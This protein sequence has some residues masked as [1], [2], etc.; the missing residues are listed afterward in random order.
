MKNLIILGGDHREICCNTSHVLILIGLGFAFKENSKTNIHTFSYIHTNFSI[1]IQRRGLL[2]PHLSKSPR[3][4]IP[5]SAET[6]G[7]KTLA[8]VINQ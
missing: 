6:V 4:R 1:F 5:G 8:P 3:P 7:D 2:R